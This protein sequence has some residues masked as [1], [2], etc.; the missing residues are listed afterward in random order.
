MLD[1]VV[2]V[3]GWLGLS[4]MSVEQWDDFN[5]MCSST[6]VVRTC[7]PSQWLV[8]KVVTEMFNAHA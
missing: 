3:D 1:V 4:N 6:P 7:E 5:M 8:A 2:R